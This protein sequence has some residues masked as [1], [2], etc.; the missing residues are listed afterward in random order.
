M[1]MLKT[2]FFLLAMTLISLGSMAATPGVTLLF[3][4]GQKASFAFAS[5][6]VIEV[7]GVILTVSSANEATVELLFPNLQR[8]YFEDDIYGTDIS[9]VGDDV[10]GSH[11]VFSYANGV[12]SVSGLS[13]GERVTVVTINGSIVTTA[14][15]DNT[16]N[17]SI[18]LCNEPAGVYVISTGKGVSF[19]LLKK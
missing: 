3:S 5:E 6:P 7:N 17:A 18:N 4:N 14:K 2:K 9:Q 19:K 16:G 12:V 1:K 13:T 10:S 11:P 8:F 15:A